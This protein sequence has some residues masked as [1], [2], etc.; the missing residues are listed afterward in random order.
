ML[1]RAFSVPSIAHCWGIEKILLRE[2]SDTLH[3]YAS[4]SNFQSMDE[5][6][7][8]LNPLD[9]LISLS[10]ASKYTGYHS[11]YLS[12]L[13]R[14]GKLQAQKIGRNWVT[15]Q[16]WINEFLMARNPSLPAG[17]VPA[18]SLDY[19]KLEFEHEENLL[20]I[21][22]EAETKIKVREIEKAEKVEITKLAVPSSPA[23]SLA[24][25]VA[26]P[27]IAPQLAEQL[28]ALQN[29]FK[30]S[31]DGLRSEFAK[32]HSI[33][34]APIQPV[35]PKFKFPTFPLPSLS[36]AAAALG[37][38]LII[39][40]A[41]KYPAELKSAGS[42]VLGNLERIPKEL[43]ANFQ[44]PSFS[45][46]PAKAGIQALDSLIQSGNDKLESVVSFLK[47]ANEK[48]TQLAQ[49]TEQEIPRLSLN[50]PRIEFPK[51]EFPKLAFKLPNFQFSISNFQT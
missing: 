35:G 51:I 15:T 38:V 44:L 12:Y 33:P 18:D 36:Q 20:K 37:L 8:N 19:K 6:D 27:E 16:A 5:Q 40:V 2:N 21:R 46:I 4:R 1:L 3:P 47:S 34:V 42:K 43:A 11:D 14:T 17:S 23:P 24:S 26:R 30:Q 39:A 41:A 9:E 13:A 10:N 31:V 48:V 25:S 50:L 7:K 49:R 28:A 22:L 32:T 29:V 45:V